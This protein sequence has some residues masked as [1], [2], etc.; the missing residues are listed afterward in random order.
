MVVF[1][2]VC[3]WP[4]IPVHDITLGILETPGDD[5]QGIAFPDPVPFLHGSP[6]PA[7]EGDAIDTPYPDMICS[8]HQFGYG[9][10]LVFPF[11]RQPYTDGWNAICRWICCIVI[12]FLESTYIINLSNKNI[13]Y[14]CRGS[15]T[16]KEYMPS[17]GC[18]FSGRNRERVLM[19]A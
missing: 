13:F 9:E 6:D 2:P 4:D 8:E 7:Q 14:K 18:D 11:F 19:P 3:L 17:Y 1:Q 10:L 15:H 5:N 16:M 12:F